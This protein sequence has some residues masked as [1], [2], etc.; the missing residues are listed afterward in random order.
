VSLGKAFAN[1]EWGGSTTIQLRAGWWGTSRVDF[2]KANLTLSTK[3]VFT[4]GTTIQDN[5]PTTFEIDPVAHGVSVCA[6]IIRNATVDIAVGGVVTI[7]V[8]K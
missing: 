3:R 5:N 6:P 7:S 2:G 4:N 8:P 1:G